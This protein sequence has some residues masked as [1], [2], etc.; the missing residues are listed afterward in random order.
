[1]EIAGLLWE[2]PYVSS[3]HRSSC[4][5]RP[6]PTLHATTVHTVRQCL[7]ISPPP[8]D[9]S[10]R[11]N[12]TVNA[13]YQSFVFCP[14]LVG[15]IFL[16]EIVREKNET[17]VSLSFFRINEMRVRRKMDTCIDPPMRSLSVIKYILKV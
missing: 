15:R 12:Y 13:L 8:W 5:Q 17:L 7:S 10:I 3:K 4:Q 2:I 1:M 11:V 16:K 6:L 14:I 9:S